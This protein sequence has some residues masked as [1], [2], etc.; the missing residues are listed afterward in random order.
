MYLFA[1]ANEDGGGGLYVDVGGLAS[2]SVVVLD[3][4]VLLNNA[5][6]SK[7]ATRMLK[8]CSK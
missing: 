1:G 5:S 4:L 7:L 2:N 3:S 6:P 8:S